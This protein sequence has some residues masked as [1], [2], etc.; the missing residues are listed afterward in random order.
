MSV[1][2]STLE[3]FSQFLRLLF[4]R[5]VLGNFKLFDESISAFAFTSSLP[6]SNFAQT[7]QFSGPLFDVLQQTSHAATDTIM[8]GAQQ[9][10]IQRFSNISSIGTD[11]VSLLDSIWKHFAPILSTLGKI[12]LCVWRSTFLWTTIKVGAGVF[13]FSIALTGVVWAYYKF[14]PITN[15]LQNA[16][17]CIVCMDNP[18]T[19]L[20]P[21]CGHLCLCGSCASAMQNQGQLFCPYCRQANQGF[22]MLRHV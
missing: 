16:L 17:S 14:N 6:A 11:V 9:E 5:R 2:V 20:S 4:S 7:A 8:L 3:N 18:K 13:V 1:V 22:Q 15:Q 19:H 21:S 12:A 10:C